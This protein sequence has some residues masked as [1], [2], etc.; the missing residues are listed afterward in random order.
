MDKPGFISLSALW[1]QIQHT[2]PPDLVERFHLGSDDVDGLAIVKRVN[3]AW[4]PWVPALR[5]QLLLTIDAF[6]QAENAKK[7]SKRDP[8]MG[9]RYRQL[10][11]TAITAGELAMQMSKLFPPPWDKH[12]HPL[13]DLLVAWA[14]SG[15]IQTTV[16]DRDQARVVAGEMIDQLR[17]DLKTAGHKMPYELMAD[18][19]WLATGR[20]KRFDESTIRRYGKN[21]KLRVLAAKVLK[22]KGRALADIARFVPNTEQSRVFMD[23]MHAFLQPPRHH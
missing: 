5:S 12:T 10:A 8:E 3:D 7:V 11:R 2:P 14:N 6:V 17:D 18:L 4:E 19:L 15:L 1:H 22:R 16:I 23:I 20:Q 9:R 13:L 21:V